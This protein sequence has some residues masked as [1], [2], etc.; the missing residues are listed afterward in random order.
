MMRVLKPNGFIYIE[1]PFLQGFHADPNDFHRYTQEGLKILLKDFKII[2]IGVS[3][4]PFCTLVWIL[5]DGL[6]SM[7]ENKIL[8]NLI[9]FF[10]SWA[11]SPLR[12]FDFL[13]RRRPVFKKLA[14]E[15]FVFVQKKCLKT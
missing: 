10:I 6:S 8:Y 1:V 3:V 2:K 5:R 13:I 7:F 14:C 9:R 11:L 12:F 15:N 4:G